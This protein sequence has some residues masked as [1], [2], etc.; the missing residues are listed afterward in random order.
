MEGITLD[1]FHGMNSAYFLGC[2]TEEAPTKRHEAP[3]DAAPHSESQR[4]T[5]F[6]DTNFCELPHPDCVLCHSEP[7]CQLI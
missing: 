5:G 7:V 3:A 1:G 4:V 6:V 2:I